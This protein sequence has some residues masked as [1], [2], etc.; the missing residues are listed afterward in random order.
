MIRSMTGYGRKEVSEGDVHFTI[1]IRSLNN[2]Y[3]DIQ[4]KS[5]R[6]LA[7]MESRVRKSVQERFSRGRFDI[8]ITRNGE[9]E[10]SGRLVVNEALAEQYI[11]ALRDLKS[12]FGL[13]G[14]VELSTVAGLQD[15]ITVA[16]ANE[17]PETLWQV[18]SPGLTQALG[19]LER[20]RAEEGAALAGDILA[21]LDTIEGL[22]S[23]IRAKAPATVEYAR[24]RMMETLGRLLTEQPDPVRVAQ[25]I[26]ILAERTDVTEE[27]TR[28]CSHLSQF[29]AVLKESSPE[30][31]GRRL[32]FLIQEMG[33]ETN[34]IASKAMDAGISLD[35]VNIKAELE[36]VREQIQN[37]E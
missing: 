1:E 34:T 19:E 22:A 30:G 21:R 35:V 29:R 25:E 32:D 16:E 3:L 36:K 24:K 17:N 20:M 23:H 8:F 12:R 33:R 31:I 18:L 27:L 13:G 2:R 7:G 5:P 4:L 28:L 15:I 14:D 37:I 6:A 11:G 10:R 9:R 26:A